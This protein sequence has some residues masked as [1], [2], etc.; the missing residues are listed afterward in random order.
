MSVPW[1]SFKKHLDFLE[2]ERVDECIGS[3][4]VA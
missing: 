4:M 3:N 2:I 1:V